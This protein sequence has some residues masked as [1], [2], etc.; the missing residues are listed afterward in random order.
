MDHPLPPRLKEQALYWART[1][2]PFLVELDEGRRSLD[3]VSQIYRKEFR[4]YVDEVAKSANRAGSLEDV[5]FIVASGEPFVN[6]THLAKTIN[7]LASI[8]DDPTAEVS[9]IP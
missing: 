9:L 6:R 3:E 5:S 2:T 7:A 4:P 8:A 1:L